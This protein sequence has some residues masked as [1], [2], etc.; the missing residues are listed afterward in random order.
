VGS[1]PR[2]AGTGARKGSSLR[3]KNW[4]NPTSLPQREVIAF[5]PP[6]LRFHTPKPS[7]NCQE[8]SVDFE[9]SR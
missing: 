4:S 8:K 7:S 3:P 1:E 2:F 9:G 6:P 5:A